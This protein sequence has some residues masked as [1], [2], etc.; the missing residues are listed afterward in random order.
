MCF[1]FFAYLKEYST[2][3]VFIIDGKVQLSYER[4]KEEGKKNRTLQILGEGLFFGHNSLIRG[5]RRN[6]RSENIESLLL[7]PIY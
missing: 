7:L 3:I 2:D 4:D 6:D 5:E 1:C